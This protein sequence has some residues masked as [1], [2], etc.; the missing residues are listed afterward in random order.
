MLAYF[1]AEQNI[2]IEGYTVRLI[3]GYRFLGLPKGILTL[4]WVDAN[5]RDGNKYWD[6]NSKYAV[7][8][9]LKEMQGI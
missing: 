9:A 4:D 7:A 5:H 8:I 6:S 1:A 2:P 3:K